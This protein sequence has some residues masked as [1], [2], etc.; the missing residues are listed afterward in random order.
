MSFRCD[1]CNEPQEHGIKPVKKVT[2]FREKSYTG[3]GH[4]W[5]IVKEKALCRPCGNRQGAPEKVLL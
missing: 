3:G 1:N 2:K 5:E 4:G